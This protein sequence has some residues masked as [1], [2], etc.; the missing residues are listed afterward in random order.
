MSRDA[1]RIAQAAHFAAQRHAGQTRKG[2]RQEPYVVHLAE[3][4]ALLAEATDGDDAGLIA[5]GWLHD[6]VEDRGV[7][8]AELAE[9]F[10]EDVADLVCEV[11]DDKSLDKAER[12]A[13]Q[14]EEAAH[15]SVRARL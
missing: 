15:K 7:A 11:T 6:A 1:V 4:A 2:A 13:R 3:V 8:R 10:G 14:V 12:K 5:A 9:R